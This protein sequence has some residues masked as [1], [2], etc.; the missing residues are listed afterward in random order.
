MANPLVSS[1]LPKP[2]EADKISPLNEKLAK[3]VQDTLEKWHING[4]AVAV[5]DGDKTWSEG[6]GLASLPDTPVKPST[7][8]W[9]GSTTKSFTASAASLLVDDKKYP[10]IM[11]ETPLSQLIREDFVVQDEYATSH[12]TLED[13]LSNRTGLPGHMLSLGREGSVRDVVRSLRHLPMDKEIRSTWQYCNAMFITVAHAIEVVTGQWLGDF[14]RERIWKPLGMNSTF[15]S[16]EDAQRHVASNEDTILAKPYAWDKESAESKELPYCEATL[17]GAG[18]II[19]NVLDYA[20]YVR[21]MIRRSGPLSEAGYK[22]LMKARSFV[23][24]MIPQFKKQVT[25][26]LGLMAGTYHGEEAIFHH[27]GLD[28]MTSTMIFFPDRDWGVVVFSNSTGLGREVLVWHLIDEFLGVPEEKR[29]DLFEMKQKSIIKKQEARSQAREKL[30]PSASFPGRPLSLAL[31]EYAGTYTHPAYPDL[32]I[33]INSSG[34]P[35]LD[36]LL[37]GAFPI[38]ITLKHVS[39]DS[40][41]LEIFEFAYEEAT[42]FVKAEF[43]VDIAR[44]VAKFGAAIDDSDM[45]NILIWFTR[46]GE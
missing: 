37:T 11:W 19:S 46:S 5:I 35:T 24:E 29:V 27:G 36:G 45:P 42:S 38:S 14:L 25:Y 32:I 15:F 8:F 30:F 12:I 6:Y 10:D 17:S 7:L 44:K 1:E 3:L 13:A 26:S 43:Y 41:V 4:V 18:A 9:T 31:E 39:G 20:K 34:D 16:L 21:S 22:E 2:T 40:F 28:G 33:S 23:P